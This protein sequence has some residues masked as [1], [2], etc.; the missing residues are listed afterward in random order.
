MRFHVKPY[1]VL[2]RRASREAR[3][4]ATPKPE[5]VFHLD[6]DTA[7]GLRAAVRAH[8]AKLGRV[9]RSIN[10]SDDSHAIVYVEAK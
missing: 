10:Q 1:T 2:N 3:A 7:D 5:A 9:V 4:T 6:V 8:Y